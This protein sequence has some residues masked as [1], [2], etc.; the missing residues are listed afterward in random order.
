[1]ATRAG[2]FIEWLLARPEQQSLGPKPNA[3]PVGFRV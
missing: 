2:R 3:Y 1:M